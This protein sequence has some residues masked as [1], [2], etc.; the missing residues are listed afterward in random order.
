MRTKIGINVIFS[1]QTYK[2]LTLL[3]VDNEAKACN[4]GKL[5]KKCVNLQRM[6]LE[7]RETETVRKKEEKLNGENCQKSGSLEKKT[8]YDV[9]NE[10]KVEKNGN[11][12][13]VV[14]KC[15]FSV[16]NFVRFITL[17]VV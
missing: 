9:D 15:T 11:L 12:N 7:D 3:K 16:C 10:N 6:R 5:K 14:G 4:Q 2:M 13:G 1:L 17:N 8:K